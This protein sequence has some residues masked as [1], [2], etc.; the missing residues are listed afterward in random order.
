[1]TTNTL[2]NDIRNRFSEKTFTI[3]SYDDAN[4]TSLINSDTAI[5]DFDEIC[6]ELV[7]SIGDNFQTPM[8]LDSIYL[9]I[10][11]KVHFIEFKN[12][13]WSRVKKDNLRLKI[14]DSIILVASMYNLDRADLEG[15]RIY[16]IHKTDAGANPTH[17]RLNGTCPPQFRLL[18]ETLGVTILKYDANTFEN[19]INAHNRLP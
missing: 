11:N 4:Q 1:M 19:Y 6:E 17:V 10:P 15:M 2:K 3:C 16:L 18:E 9:S 14:Y 5:Y 8:S 13:K 7:S 12:T